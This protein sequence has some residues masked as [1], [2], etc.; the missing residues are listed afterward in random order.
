MGITKVKIRIWFK[1]NN[2]IVRVGPRLYPV[3][4]PKSSFSELNS[5]LDWYKEHTIPEVL[6]NF[7]IK[8]MT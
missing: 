5:G 3:Q 8:V 7:N 2:W 1:D 4:L 6:R